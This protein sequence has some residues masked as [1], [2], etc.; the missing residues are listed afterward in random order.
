MAR[1]LTI[2]M[3]IAAVLARCE[4]A[5]APM[6]LTGYRADLAVFL[7]WALGRDSAHYPVAPHIIAAFVEEEST[8]V[9][10]STLRRRLAAIRFIHVYGDLPDPTKASAVRLAM[11]RA[12]LRTQRRPAQAEGL[13]HDRL[14]AI[15]AA[16]P[17]SLE[18]LRDGALI[19]VGYDTLCR[20]CE[21]V[22]LKV[23]DLGIAADA[24]SI[25]IRR[26]KS[27][28]AGDG[29][30]AWLSQDTLE[31]VRAWMWAAGVGEGYLFRAVHRGYASE[32]PLV[33]S[34]VRR[35][36]KRA[37]ERAGLDEAGQRLSG[38][39]MRVGGAQDML[40]AGFDALA[41]MQAG[42]WKTPHI[43]LRYV[44]QAHTEQLHK[45]RWARLNNMTGRHH[46][47]HRSRA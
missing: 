2:E 28:Q 30:V 32:E 1:S 39:S 20:S 21:L 6:T 26:A 27:D 19:G 38:H 12:S 7:R 8:R 18:G 4:G 36:V 42:G 3:Q 29:R 31:R 9:R 44:E 17:D 11:R 33:N 41:I 45:E 43:V 46:A 5:F 22:R 34:S 23:E 13:T 16:C 25:L 40:L 14:K 24:G 37:A 15:L 10:P 47:A 35:L